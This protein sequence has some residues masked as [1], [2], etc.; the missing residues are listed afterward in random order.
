MQ[1]TIH[2]LSSF[3]LIVQVLRWDWA[4]GS[5]TRPWA[6]RVKAQSLADGQRLSRA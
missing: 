2:P 1:A 5:T 4:L 6:R 3:V